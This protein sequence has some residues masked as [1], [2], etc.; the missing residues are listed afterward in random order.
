MD[1]SKNIKN[2]LIAIAI[3]IIFYFIFC[4][5]R[6]VAIQNDFSLLNECQEFNKE[7]YLPHKIGGTFYG[8]CKICPG[9]D[10]KTLIATCKNKN[11]KYGSIQNFDYINCPIGQ[12][13]RYQVENI[14]GTLQCA[15]PCFELPNYKVPK[16]IGGS[17]SGTCMICDTTTNGILKAKC[18]DEYGNYNSIQT[19]DYR[20][21]PSKDGP[22]QIDNI[23][24]NLQCYGTPW[25]SGM[26]GPPA[27]PPPPTAR[28]I[29]TTPMATTTIPATTIPATTIPATTTPIATTTPVATTTRRVR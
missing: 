12:N 19:F 16:N 9:T 18:K 20:N 8:S 5:N 28:P 7:K 17:F 27:P 6:N 11:N 22:Y 26:L 14:K 29:T 25:M 10:E 1:N 4:Y 21:C 3:L 24:G 23:N 13:G 15:F 2:I